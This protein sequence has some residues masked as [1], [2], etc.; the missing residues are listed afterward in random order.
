MAKIIYTNG[1]VGSS[2]Y[3][4]WKEEVSVHV[5]FGETDLEWEDFDPSNPTGLEFYEMSVED[6]KKLESDGV[7]NPK[8]SYYPN[9]V[10]EVGFA[11]IKHLVTKT[12]DW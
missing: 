11:V 12:R 8:I 3:D 10:A 6:Y 2:M 5:G 4:Q 7:I 9:M 1:F